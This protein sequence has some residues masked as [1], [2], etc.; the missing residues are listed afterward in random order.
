MIDGQVAERL[1]LSPRTVGRHLTSIY[2][3]LNVATRAAATRFAV[4]Q[5][6]T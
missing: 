2:R 1:A 5:R 3:K 4:E 6:L